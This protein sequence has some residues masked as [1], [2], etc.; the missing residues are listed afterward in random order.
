MSSRFEGTGAER[1]ADTFHD[2]STMKTVAISQSNYVPWKGYFDHIAAVDE[3]V[4]FD[5]A[6]YTRRDWRNR[7]IIVTPVGRKW[8]TIPVKAKGRYLQRID[9]TEVDGAEWREAHW[10][11]LERNYGDAPYFRDYAGMFERLYLHSDEVML[12]RINHAFLTVVCGILGIRTKLSWSTDYPIVG[13]KTVRLVALCKEV[14][15]TRYVSGPTARGYIE[16][17]LFEEAQISLAYMDYAGY[18]E[19]K[20]LHGEFDHGVSVLDLIFNTGAEAP[21]Y[22]KHV[23]RQECRV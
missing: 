2:K 21:R 12:S 10:R 20:Q 18:P 1:I 3:F 11:A 23:L 8:L 13:A 22:M 19:Y 16:P 15:A 6:Q 4:L 14:R 9:E 17:H 5:N 7:N